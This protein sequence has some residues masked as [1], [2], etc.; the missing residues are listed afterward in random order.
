[1]QKCRESS[2]PA[3]PQPSKHLSKKYLKTQSFYLEQGLKKGITQDFPRHHPPSLRSKS[4]PLIPKNEEYITSAEV[5]ITMKTTLYISVVLAPYDLKI[6]ICCII[7]L[8]IDLC[9]LYAVACKVWT[10]ESRSAFYQVET[11]RSTQ[12]WQDDV[13]A[14]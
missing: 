7:L 10:G 3:L 2:S 11:H 13:Q 14:H 8:S 4:K 1:M 12:Q 5:R 6:V 9:P